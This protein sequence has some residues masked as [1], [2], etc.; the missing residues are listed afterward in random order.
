MEKIFNLFGSFIYIVLKYLEIKP[1]TLTS[2][3]QYKYDRFLFRPI[4]MEKK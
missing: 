1:L 2:H 4:T 3:F